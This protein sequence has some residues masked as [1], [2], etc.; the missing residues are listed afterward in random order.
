MEKTIKRHPALK[1]FSRDHHFGLLLCWK[2]RE[3]FRRNVEPERMKKYT[4]W[5]FESYQKPHFESEEKYMFSLLP[6]DDRQKKRAIAEHRR[7][8]RLFNDQE[9]VKR[10]LSLIEEELDQHIRFEERIL[11]AEIQKIATEEQLQKIEEVHQDP[12][13]DDWGDEFWK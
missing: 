4:D 5:F 3:G 7:L 12:V 13:L 2:I 1:Q 10:A 9:E 8:E 6:D 11:F